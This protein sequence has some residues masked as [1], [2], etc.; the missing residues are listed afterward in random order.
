MNQALVGRDKELE[1]VRAALAGSGHTGALITGP[2]GVGKTRLAEEAVAGARRR[3]VLHL[4][5]TVAAQQ[6]P[7]APL[8]AVF[9]EVTGAPEVA[10]RVIHARLTGRSSVPVLIVDDVQW[11]DPSTLTVLHLLARA[12]TARVLA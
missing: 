12:R 8:L 10:T 11:L 2:A 3:G 7:L 4:A 5:G 9:P 6:I 1:A